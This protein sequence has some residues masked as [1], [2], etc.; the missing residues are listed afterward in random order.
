MVLTF[1]LVCVFQCSNVVSGV[2][3]DINAF[4]MQFRTS[5]HWAAVL[6]LTEILGVLMEHGA[7]PNLTDSVGATA[8]HYAVCGRGR[9]SVMIVTINYYVKV[10]FVDGYLF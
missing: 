8:L 6:G 7:D 9:S 3:C 2:R 4:D 5:L 10:T 1:V